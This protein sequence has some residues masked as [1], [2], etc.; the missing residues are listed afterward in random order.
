MTAARLGYGTKL[1]MGDGGSPEEFVEIA[2]VGDFED[3]DTAELVEVT[4]HQSTN[5]RR[6][7]IAGLIDGDEIQIPCNYIPSNATQDR[8]TGLQSKLRSTVNFRLEE[9]GN[10]EGIAF[11]GVVLG[12]SKSYP[13]ADKM[14]MTVTIKKTGSPTYYTIV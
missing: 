11:S 8:I 4:N 12:I 3:T 1:K 2:E 10:S 9:P 13:V 7:Y 14:M 6:E 5:S